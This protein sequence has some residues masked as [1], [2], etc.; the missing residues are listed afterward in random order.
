MTYVENFPNWLA[1][2]S[3]G[4]HNNTTEDNVLPANKNSEIILWLSLSV[5]HHKWAWLLLA[6]IVQV[7]IR[8]GI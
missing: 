8:D 6:T 1:E 2:C 5:N 3:I 7:C 4:K